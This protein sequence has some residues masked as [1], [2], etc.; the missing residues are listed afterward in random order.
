M[1]LAP[2]ARELAVDGESVMEMFTSDTKL[3]MSPAYLKPVFAFGGSCLPKDVRALNYRGKELE[4]KLPLIES[5]LPS[6]E[7]HLGRAVQMV[8]QTGK[9]KIGMLGLGFK[10]ATD[11]L[12]ESPQ[13]QLTKRLLGEGRDIQIWD[14]SVSLGQLIGSNR[15]YIEQVIPHI[16]SLLTLNLEEVLRDAELVVIGTRG[17][18]IDILSKSL[19]RDQIVVDLVNLERTRRLQSAAAY[20]GICW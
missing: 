5:I 11:D 9:R 17:L 16:G 7:E 10:E 19:R 15:E 3:N 8:L 14:D 1:K 4:V 2:P 12:R 18:D 6:N 20:K 13:V